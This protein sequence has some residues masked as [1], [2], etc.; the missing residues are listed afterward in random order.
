MI[1]YFK[2]LSCVS[3]K[4][5]VFFDKIVLFASFLPIAKSITNQMLVFKNIHFN[6]AKV[7]KNGYFIELSG[8][9]SKITLCYIMNS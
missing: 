4:L 2:T 3:S 8:S 7:K 6:M 5:L 9:Y 1:F